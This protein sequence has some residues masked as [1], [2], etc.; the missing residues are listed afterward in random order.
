MSGGGVRKSFARGIEAIKDRVFGGIDYEKYFRKVEDGFS[1]LGNH[2]KNIALLDPEGFGI[3][4]RVRIPVLVSQVI[5]KNQKCEF[6]P[7]KSFRKTVMRVDRGKLYVKGEAFPVMPVAG[8]GVERAVMNDSKQLYAINTNHQ[9]EALRVLGLDP[10]KYKNKRLVIACDGGKVVPPPGGKDMRLMRAVYNIE[11]S[12]E[13][14]RI[15]NETTGATM[16]PLTLLVA[17]PL[18]LCS[19]ILNVALMV[20]HSLCHG[21]TK[22][23]DH[24][25]SNLEGRARDLSVINSRG[26]VVGVSSAVPYVLGGALF[27]CCE[28]AVSAISSAVGV[29][30]SATTC[31]VRSVPIF[32]NAAYNCSGAQLKIG[33]SYLTS[34]ASSIGSSFAKYGSDTV[35]HARF[36][37]NVVGL[38]DVASQEP[39]SNDESGK[40]RS[41][42]DIRDENAKLSA[43][44]T[45]SEV[46]SGEVRETITLGKEDLLQVRTEGKDLSA[47]GVTVGYGTAEQVRENFANSVGMTGVAL[48]R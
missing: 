8:A 5:D 20:P 46:A 11:L 9:D 27:R 10:S 28:R 45:R 2:V 12:P 17:M 33:T 40:L 18:N 21:V 32:V 48:G 7:K 41:D 38:Q 35:G 43:K 3:Q 44:P 24:V 47:V 34:T 30:R 4:K 15:C 16:W 6:L 39:I 29:V 26:T 36:Y 1:F 25:A 14:R 19:G 22:L 13:T 37:K 23:L 42:V 31:V